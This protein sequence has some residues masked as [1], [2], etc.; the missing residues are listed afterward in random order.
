MKISGKIKSAPNKPGIY[1]FYNNK[2]AL[3]YVGKA[4]NLKSRIR[5]YFAGQKSPRPIEIFID[6]VSNIKWI[7]TDSVLEAIILEA[8]YIKKHLPKYN[9]LGKDDKSWN[10]LYLTED[11]FPQLKSIR[12][13]ELHN[14]KFIIHNS[15]FWGPFP[16]LNTK[17]TFKILRKLFN[18]SDC[19]PDQGKPC[20]YNQIEQCLGVCTG[21]ITAKEYKQKVISPLK[22]FLSGKKEQVIR[23]LEK[24]IKNAVREEEFEE[25]GRL[26]DQIA[27][28][29]KI[30]DVSLLNDSLFSSPITKHFSLLPL[31][32]HKSPITKIEGYD[33][34]N[35]GSTG[36]VGS[37]VTFVN[38]EP[39]KRDYKKFKIKTVVGQS[40]VHC[41]AEV[42]RRRLKHD[43]WPLPNIILVDGGKPQL[44]T[45]KREILNSKFKIP[46]V[47][48]AK[49]KDRKK[50]QF[51]IS[52]KSIAGWV[53]ENKKTLIQVRDEAH[54][55]AI[56][57]QR[58]LRKIKK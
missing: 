4:T 12:Q 46:V 19:K 41:L 20:F 44:S 7:E 37:L 33:I 36:K 45:A 14:S 39:S 26:R 35:L 30:H 49:G 51:F 5:S 34:S 2:R 24:K 13:H 10:Y 48:I 42:L 31:T 43:D 1:L 21:E 6:E 9:V 53:K 16:G 32:T 56:K 57:Y 58:Q 50:N 22:R 27:N 55:F 23:S 17:A 54:R 25:A 52:D 47:G 38:G 28:L 3:I 29:K 11:E 18:Y 8:R 40:D 15:S